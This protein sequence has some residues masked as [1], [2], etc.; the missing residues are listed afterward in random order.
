MVHSP[1]LSE[2]WVAVVED[3]ASIRCAIARFLGVYGIRTETFG[4]AEEFLCRGLPAT[5][6]CIVLDVQLG[7]MSGF[8]LQD[9]LAC[10]GDE[11]PII[12]MTAQ[13]ELSA[14]QLASRARGLGFLRKPFHP[15]ALLALVQPHLALDACETLARS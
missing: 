14:E 15:E 13:A 12:F 2:L 6:R 3:E 8:E 4:S 9:L 7:G 10:R 5:P 11:L 1:T